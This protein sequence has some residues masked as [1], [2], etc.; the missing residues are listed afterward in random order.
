MEIRA[1]GTDRMRSILVLA[2][3]LGVL[4]FN[5]I[6]ATGRVGSLDTGTISD[7]Y[8]TVLTPAGYAFS[9]WTLIYIGL[10]AFSVWQLLP[11]NVTRFRP[12][13]SLYVF[14]C[15]LNC[16]WL[17]FWHADQIVLCFGI[18]AALSATLAVINYLLRQP[19]SLADGWAAKAPFG[20]YFG[21]VTVATM[22]NFMVMLKYLRIDLSPPVE[23][24]LGVVLILLAA[25]I[26]VVVRLK[27][28]NYFFPL[29]VAWGLT[30]IAVRQSGRTLVVASAAAGVVACLIA[31]LSFVM[32]LRS[33]Q[34]REAYNT[35]HE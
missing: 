19:E 8:P 1:T 22:V 26:G 11:A 16:A 24:T 25:A 12:L 3:T 9:I 30:A 32:S 13:R 17:Y 35:P 23:M 10:V 7:L 27:L 2:A 29:A 5:W 18:L 21:W 34:D 33:S 28:M 31:S 4:V 15:A 20:L 14:S 6:A